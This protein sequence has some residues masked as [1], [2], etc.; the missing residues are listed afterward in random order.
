MQVASH[1]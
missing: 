1:T